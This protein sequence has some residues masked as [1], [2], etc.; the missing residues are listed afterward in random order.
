MRNIKSG[1]GVSVGIL[2]LGLG[3][4]YIHRQSREFLKGPTIV[5]DAIPSGPRTESFFTL[6]GHAS[7]VAFLSLNDS[8]IYTDEKGVFREKLLLMPGYNILQIKAKD[9]FG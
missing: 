6:G 8:Q 9:K 2:I 3:G 5:L 7:N 4:V 1:L